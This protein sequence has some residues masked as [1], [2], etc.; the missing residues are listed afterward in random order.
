MKERKTNFQ[1]IILQRKGKREIKRITQG[2]RDKR[3]KKYIKTKRDIQERKELNEQR[4][5]QED[6]ERKE[7]PTLTEKEIPE[8]RVNEQRHKLGK[9][10]REIQ[11]E[12]TKEKRGT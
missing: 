7:I 9:R 2:T 3:E 8:R 10:Q 6:K 12:T 1:K 11:Q 5:Q 4:L